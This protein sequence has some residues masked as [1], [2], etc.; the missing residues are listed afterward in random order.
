MNKLIHFCLNQKL[1]VLILLTF[2]AGW[3]ARV[4][5]FDWDTGDFPRDPVAVDAIPDLG[6]NQQIIFTEYMGRSPQDV[7][8]QI[9]YPLTVS[10][11]GIPG[12]KEVRSYSM[13]GF[14]YVYLIFEEDVDYYWSRSRI[15]EK[16]N[17]LPAGLLPD[18]VIPAL[19]PDATGLGQVYQYF[20][21]GQDPNGKPTP[22]WNP[23]ELRSLQDWYVRYSLL[24]AEGVA[25][26]ASVG[27]FVKQYQVEVDPIKLQA[28]NVTLAQV[29]DAVRKSNMETGARNLAINGVEYIL[30]GTGYIKTLED[31]EDAVVTV[32]DNTP[33]TVSQVA[34]VQLGPAPRRGAIDVNGADAA[35]GIVVARYGA[36][37]LQTIKNA[38]AKVKEVSAALPIKGVID[39]GQTSR[40]EVVAFAEKNNISPIFASDD[41]A[42]T[43]L[44]HDT[45]THWGNTHDM[46][47]WPSWFNTSK[48]TIV[49]FYDRSAL[50][51]ETLNTLD[52]ALY[53]Q[54]LV[55]II[56]VV[57]MVLHLRSSILIS[58]MLP[59]AVLLTF[60]AM[61]LF[62]VDAN[63][64]ALSG[65]AIAI[66]TVVDV[67]IVLTE[68]IIKH[69]KEAQENEPDKPSATVIYE[70]VTE[71]AGAVTTSVMT[72]VVSFLPV[73][74]MTGE[75]GRL[76]KPLAYTKSF[77]LIASIIVALT[78]I[79]PIAHFL[80]GILPRWF[81]RD[82][83][84]AKYGNTKFSARTIIITSL[85]G[86]SA[87]V[88]LGFSTMLA[89]ALLVLAVF[90]AFQSKIPEKF[91][92]AGVFVINVGTALVIGWLL[93]KNWMPL[94]LDSSVTKNFL[95]VLIILGGLL[96]TFKVFEVAYP[97]ILRWCLHHKAMFLSLPVMMLAGAACIW[98]G[99][100][101]VTK[102]FP[103]FAKD[104]DL[105]QAIEKRFP[106]LGKEF[107]PALD[108]GSFLVMPTVSPHASIEEANDALRTLDAAI[109]A[110]PEVKQVVG[111]IGRAESALD[112]APISMIETIVNYKSEYRTDDK[113]DV[114]TF[115][116]N[117]KE[118]YVYD[119]RGNLIED[120]DGK[121]FRQWR[122]EIKTVDDIWQ[123]ISKVTKVPGVTGAPKLQPIET[124]LVMLR[125]GMRAPMGI[126]VKAPTLESLEEFGLQ[127]ERL[128]RESDI[129]GLDKSSINA[130]RI[131]G[132]PYLEINPDREAAK[133]YG[134]N[135]VDIHSTIQTAIGGEIVSTT[136][137][138]RERYGIQVRYAREARD[139]IESIKKILIQTKGG[140][141][142][143]LGQVVSID[144]VR[145]PQV[146]K[147]EDTFLT[148]YVTF[149]SKPGFAE[150][151]VVESIQEYLLKMEDNGELKRTGGIRYEF[152]GNY[153]SA[154]EFDKNM[155]IIMPLALLAI[156]LILYLENRSVANTFIIFSGIAVAF[157]GG[158]L[159]LWLY[160]QPGFLNVVIF[161]HDLRELFQIHPINLSTAVWVGFI[162][163]FGI[164]TDDGVVISTYLRQRFKKDNPQTIEAIRATA[165]LAGQ[166]RCRPCLMTTATT[167]LA[168]LP[169]LT[170][171]GR[172]ADIM[173]P[174]A[175]P[176][177]GGMMVELLTMFV[178]PTLFCAMQEIKNK[179][180][181]RE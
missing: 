44:N 46:E 95:F 103:Q 23:E 58:A 110:I 71:V 109:A 53:Q 152:A 156:F 36:N 33:I 124:R 131:V 101:E 93:A 130:D 127:L 122:P 26:V 41:P 82:P 49:P 137:E 32:R 112:P 50:I 163:L 160:A 176:I 24:G 19:G 133:R 47:N 3:G 145:G 140:A 126:K 73:F 125:T 154:L 179:V 165:V 62:G 100:G 132:K 29:A 117:D 115:K 147:S 9:S 20:L 6:D 144:Y 69:V 96:L 172:G 128:M 114:L 38:K 162:A 27:G 98:M 167:L 52:E 157:S 22:G 80:L 155:A 21:E 171:T 153:Q 34:T 65:I 28:W 85:L 8:D 142:V 7:E 1:V 4:A 91:E 75:A 70:A 169:V 43:E 97:H 177:F 88:A 148:G 11:L 18:G 149:G 92:K 16:L 79:P 67:G 81:K 161:G 111:K 37:P 121:P 159:L 55:T 175:V 14:S 17:S 78:I 45:W 25:E 68:N 139:N 48:V 99:F 87:G 57:I 116:I 64:V 135:V 90:F 118:D 89:L 94:G 51:N 146:I 15:L 141:Q 151:D 54:I 180:G 113:G 143:P 83:N 108:E 104:S 106:G 178:V 63:I 86:I 173:G 12:V 39:W 105:Y 31:L 170:S 129:P 84:E 61:K 123:E 102:S 40:K 119:K 181:S 107:R 13:F 166:R 164:A 174:M 150:V 72:T 158:F 76:Y 138:G 10:L 66:G 30:R 168:L 59:L 2:V 5:P 136:V 60:I 134:L 120:P 77:A 74:T 35:G 56:V 42:D